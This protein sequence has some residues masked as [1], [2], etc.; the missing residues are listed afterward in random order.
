MRHLLAAAAIALALTGCATNP[1]TGK[2]ELHMVSEAQEIQIGEQQYGP[3]RQ[4][5]GGD[6]VTDPKVTEYVR[7]VGNRLAAVDAS[8]TAPGRLNSPRHRLARPPPQ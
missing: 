8:F 7:Q 2:K 5:Q 3:G 6:Y 1:V 4:S